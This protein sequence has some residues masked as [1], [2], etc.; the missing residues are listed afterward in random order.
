MGKGDD[1]LVMFLEGD[2]GAQAS[3]F[4]RGT[5]NFL[6]RALNGYQETDADLAAMSDKLGG[7]DT[8]GDYGAGLAWAMSAPFP[9]FTTF[10]SHLGST[11]HA[12]DLSLPVP[13]KAPG[14]Q[15]E[16]R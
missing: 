9:L 12:L 8:F 3:K 6:S 5:L 4:P 10:A 13:I 1:T 16:K 2:N 11:A 15:H 7:P 14:K